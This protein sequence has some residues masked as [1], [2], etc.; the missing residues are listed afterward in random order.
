[1]PSQS[2]NPYPPAAVVQ[3]E[4][5]YQRLDRVLAGYAHTASK[6]RNH[7]VAIECDGAMDEPATVTVRIDGV[8]WSRAEEEL[9]E[10]LRDVISAM[11][12]RKAV[13]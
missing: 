12:A 7:L 13:R 3:H 4:E 2:N 5:E 8:D 1:M 6:L 9:E 10:T 11:E